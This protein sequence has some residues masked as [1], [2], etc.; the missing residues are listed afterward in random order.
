MPYLMQDGQKDR[1]EL[2]S[3]LQVVPHLRGHDPNAKYCFHPSASMGIHRLR[4]ITCDDFSPAL[5][6][7]VSLASA[8]F[9]AF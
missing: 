4:I 2:F 3:K 8:R 7:D 5:V 1:S 9:V 6:S